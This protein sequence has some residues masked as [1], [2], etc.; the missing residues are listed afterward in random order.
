MTSSPHLTRRALLTGAASPIASA[1]AQPPT[2]AKPWNVLML[3]ADDMND[4]GF[5]NSYPGIQM[6]NLDKLKK[7]SLVFDRAYCAS[8]ACVPSRAAVFSGLYP[9]S[10]GAYRNGSDPWTKSPLDKTEN[11]PEC[12][13]RNGYLAFGRGKILHAPLEPSREKALWDNQYFGGGFGPFPPEK[14]REIAKDRFWGTTAWEG[15]DSDFPDVVNAD[16]AVALLG[17]KHDKPFFLSYGVWRPHTPFTAPKRFFDM[18]RAADMRVP[19]AGYR[20]GDLDDT[21]AEAHMLAKV[22]G[23][24]FEVTGKNNPQSWRRFLHAYAACTTFADH[25]LGRVLDALAASPHAENT[26]VVFWSDNGYHC[27]EKDHW[28]KTTL[29]EQSARVPMAIR[30]PGITAPGSRCARTVG[31]IDIYPTLAELCNLRI[32]PKP[33]E[34]RSLSPLLRRPRAQWD[35]P[36]LT[37]YGEGY[38]SV[39]DERFR[40]IRYPDQTEE[41]YNH[42]EDPHEFRNIA[43]GRGSNRIKERLARFIPNQWAPTLGGR[44]G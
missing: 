5:F 33:L 12:F 21:P 18:Y 32:G 27:G 31:L 6:P 13:K 23:E 29:W 16:A 4:Y 38:A 2:P 11:M 28:E 41:L 44:L 7:S 19:P 39:R 20:D 9:H 24:R 26:I 22:W 15:P 34:G 40:Y 8:P 10:T 30:V 37:T 35:H 17:Q 36:A 42:T 3:I 43:A 25:S 14:D 1:L